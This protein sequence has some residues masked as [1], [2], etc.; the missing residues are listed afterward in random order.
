VDDAHPSGTIPEALRRYEARRRVDAA[1][2]Q[3]RQ[4]AWL[5]RVDSPVTAVVRDLFLRSI[6]HGTF[7][8]SFR[9]FTYSVI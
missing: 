3:S 4:L 7:K 8:A 2:K 9:P 1:Q 5:L 6:Q